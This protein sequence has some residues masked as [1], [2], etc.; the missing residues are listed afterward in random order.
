MGELQ[1]CY[2]TEWINAQLMKYFKIKQPGLGV[3]HTLQLHREV[4]GPRFW[5]SSPGSA[6]VPFE[7]AGLEPCLS[8]ILFIPKAM[9]FLPGCV[10]GKGV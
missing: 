1:S 2:I 6:S 5:G 7:G 10:P 8:L 4:C 3:V 9:N